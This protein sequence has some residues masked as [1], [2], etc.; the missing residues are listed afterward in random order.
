MPK[1]GDKIRI[2]EMSESPRHNG[3]EGIVRKV[4]CD[5]IRGTWGRFPLLIGFDTYIVIE[6][7]DKYA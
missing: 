7:E 6:S 3:K 2:I 5:E 1:V 4:D